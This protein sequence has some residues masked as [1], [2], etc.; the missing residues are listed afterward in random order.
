[1]FRFNCPG[2][3][4]RMKTLE[5][6]AG[7][8]ITCPKCGLRQT[9]PTPPSYAFPGRGP[10]GPASATTAAVTRAHAAAARRV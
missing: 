3:G 9:V 6:R 7:Q 8:E 4:K 10:I 1:M 2:C 5:D